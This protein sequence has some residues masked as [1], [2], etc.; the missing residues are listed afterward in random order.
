VTGKT[1]P[2][3]ITP[4]ADEDSDEDAE[5]WHCDCTSGCGVNDSDECECVS[6]FGMSRYPRGI[7]DQGN[8]YTDPGSADEAGKLNLDALPQN[9]PLVE[10]GPACPCGSS[11]SNRV[12]QRGL[13]YVQQENGL[14]V[15]SQYMSDLATRSV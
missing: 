1:P 15:E 13:M 14:M 9:M 2:I 12:T 11:C 4:P 6:T 8:F 3:E 5:E 10:C 7:D